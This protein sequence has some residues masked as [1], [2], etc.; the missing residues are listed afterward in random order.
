LP[1]PRRT[2]TYWA[3][4]TVGLALIIG[5]VILA[6]RG[7]WTSAAIASTAGTLVAKYGDNFETKQD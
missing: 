2:P 4:F 6:I 3:A 1:R 5:G 7:D